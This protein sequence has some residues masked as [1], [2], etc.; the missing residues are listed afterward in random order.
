MS[1]YDDLNFAPLF[2]TDVFATYRQAPAWLNTNQVEPGERRFPHV[3]NSAA[4]NSVAG[5]IPRQ[6]A[7]PNPGNAITIGIDT[8]VVAYQPVAF[9]AATKVYELRSPHLDAH[10]GLVLVSLLRR[11]IEKFS[12]GHKA[13]AERLR[14]TRI[15]VPV[16]TNETGDQMIDWDGMTRLGEELLASA[17]TFVQNAR[18]NGDFD[19]ES[20]LPDL[21]FEPMFITDVFGSMKSST[22]WYDKAKLRATGE[23]AYPFVSRTKASNGVDGFISKQEKAPERGNAITIGLDTQTVAYQPVPFY[24]SQNI[25]IL[26]HPRLNQDAA[27][28]LAA[29]LREQMGKFSWG[30]NGATLGRLKKTRIMVPVVSSSPLERVVDWDGMTRYG[31]IVRARAE[32]DMSVVVGVG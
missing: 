23:A 32:R 7:D 28:V 27:L 10:N 11:A 16:T 22:A 18:R 31:R 4:G 3:T 9:Y 1:V 14:K 25:Q 13:S 21:Q 2:I 8:Q 29:C 20:A 17:V 30:G 24:T 15:M 6:S 5:F 19:A 26:R 12:W